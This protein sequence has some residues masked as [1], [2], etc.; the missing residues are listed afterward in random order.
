MG[1]AKP[2][3]SLFGNIPMKETQPHDPT[4]TASDEP[5]YIEMPRGDIRN[6]QVTIFNNDSHS[7]VEFDEI[8]VTFKKN[9]LDEPF[10]FQYKLSA[11]TVWEV[12][13]G[14]YE[15]KIRAADTENLPAG[16][17]VFDIELIY[18]GTIKQTTVGILKL[19]QDVTHTDDE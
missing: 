6:V 5:L 12:D 10:L 2:M 3:M 1:I 16:G 14:I 9:S 7:D 11:G 15:F 8:Y 19:T 18:N 17:Y 4:E 13:T